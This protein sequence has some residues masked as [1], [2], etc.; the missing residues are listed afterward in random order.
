MFLQEVGL[1]DFT[2]VLRKRR[3]KG[4]IM[5]NDIDLFL[6]YIISISICIYLYP[7]LHEQ[8]LEEEAAVGAGRVVGCQVGS[9]QQELGVV[10]QLYMCIG[11]QS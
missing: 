6:F 2:V 1:L 5:D 10:G 7:D 8:Y 4:K 11:G 3:R 9:D